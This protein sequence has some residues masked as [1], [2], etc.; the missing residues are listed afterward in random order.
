MINSLRDDTRTPTACKE[1]HL[2][3]ATS[4]DLQRLYTSQS[5][6]HLDRAHSLINDEQL[7]EACCTWSNMTTNNVEAFCRAI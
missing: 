4:A 1:I 7:R 5:A 6:A 3:P 2:A